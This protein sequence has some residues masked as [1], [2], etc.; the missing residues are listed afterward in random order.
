MATKFTHVY[1]V[2]PVS[3]IYALRATGYHQ[4]TQAVPMHQA[5]VY[6]TS[7]YSDAV[8]WFISYVAHNKNLKHEQHRSTRLR[9]EG[10]GWQEEPHYYQHATIYKIKIPKWVLEKSWYNN[11]WEHEYFITYIDQLKI[12]WS[13][14]YTY[15][16]L[17]QWSRRHDAYRNE[18]NCLNYDTIA[19]RTPHNPA[20]QIYLQLKNHYAQDRLHGAPRT[21]KQ[22]DLLRELLPYFCQDQY[23]QPHPIPTLTS[24]QK[25]ELKPLIHK[26]QQIITPK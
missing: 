19:K 12:I 1:H 20:A 2:S 17:I 18:I 6:V 21:L 9:D 25:Q 13:R 5:G 11:N 4:G 16:E 22:E 24:T 14:T 7:T 10:R 15:H 8:E 26:I 3:H 23:W